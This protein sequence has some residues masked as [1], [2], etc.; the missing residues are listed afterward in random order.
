MGTNLTLTGDCVT[1]LFVTNH[2][3]MKR[4]PL[5]VIFA[6]FLVSASVYQGHDPFMM[7]VGAIVALVLYFCC[8]E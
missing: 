6:A 4:L 1:L 2:H 5:S 7:W 8:K 3:A